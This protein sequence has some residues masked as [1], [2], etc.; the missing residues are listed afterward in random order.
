MTRSAGWRAPHSTVLHTLGTHDQRYYMLVFLPQTPLSNSPGIVSSF[1]R[2]ADQEEEVGGRWLVCLLMF[3]LFFFARPL[4][5]KAQAGNHSPT[6]RLT[7]RD[8]VFTT[9]TTP[10]HDDGP[11]RKSFFFLFLPSSSTCIYIKYKWMRRF[12][13]G[14]YWHNVR[15][16]RPLAAAAWL[17]AST[18]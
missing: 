5:P 17:P 6:H 10:Q 2:S 16:F 15:E 13:W 8:G 4:W 3:V 11:K 9:S 12:A 1:K 18:R 7:R 14:Q